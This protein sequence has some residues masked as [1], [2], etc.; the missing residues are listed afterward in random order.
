M[1]LKKAQ[2]EVLLSWIAEGLESDEINKRAAKFKPRFKVTRQQV[3]HYRKTRQTKLGELKEAGEF[4]ALRTGLAKVQARVKLLQDLAEK[5]RTDLFDNEL[6][7]L[8]QAKSVGTERFYYRD[9]NASE[10]LQ[11]RGVLDDI[12]QEI[13]E[14]GKTLE[15]KGN[16]G[17]F[18]METWKEDR[19]KRMNA[20]EKLEE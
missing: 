5:L 18:D 19:K 4:D 1:K 10:V 6:L 7:W 14:R 20:I 13:G 8:E 17:L 11:L 12:A 16:I 15:H 9:F 2:R 3:D